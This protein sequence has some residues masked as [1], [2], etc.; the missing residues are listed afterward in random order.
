MAHTQILKGKTQIHIKAEASPYTYDAPDNDGTGIII[1]NDDVSIT[2]DGGPM[3]NNV[4]RGDFLRMAR[5]K[6]QHSITISFSVPLKGSAAAGTPPEWTEAARMCGCLIFDNGTTST[7]VT[8]T[9]SFSGTAGSNLFPEESYSMTVLNDGTAHGMANG[10]GNMKLVAEVDS[11]PRLEFTMSGRYQA[12]ADDGVE[13]A[14][15]SYDAQIAQPFLGVS[16]TSNFGGAYTVVA[17]SAI[18]VDL[19]NVIAMGRDAAIHTGGTQANA[20][21]NYGARI[22]G[23]HVTGSVT[24]EKR[25]QATGNA[26][27]YGHAAAATVGSFLTGT[28]GATAGNKWVLSIPTCTVGFPTEGD[29]D[30][31]MTWEIPF[32][33]HVPVTIDEDTQASADFNL[34]IT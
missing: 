17:C 28:V 9:S 24:M 7:V 32:D 21:G 20:T 3:D 30:G 18:S 33:A 34:T 19:G 1:V 15:A 22:T 23:H 25:L 8:P 10:Y 13:D 2:V 16:M 29:N 31:I 26:D 12:Y 5:S 4:L 11:V 14:S 6:G 27:F